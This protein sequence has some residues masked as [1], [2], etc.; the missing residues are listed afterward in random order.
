MIFSLEEFMQARGKVMECS[1]ALKRSGDVFNDHPQIGMM[2]EVPAVIEI[3]EEF[4]RIVD[5][6]S[7]GTNDLVQYMLAVDRTNEEVAA[8]YIPHHPA[9]LRAVKR[10][11]DA[12]KTSGKEVSVCGDMV[13]KAPY[14]QFLIGCGIRTLSMNPIYLAENQKIIGEIDV[15]KAEALTLRLLATGDISSIENELLAS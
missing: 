4:A 3:I 13:N 5:F 11:A 1:D 2:V 12:A 10:V 9:V 8:Y 14:L 7:I 15:V 6:F